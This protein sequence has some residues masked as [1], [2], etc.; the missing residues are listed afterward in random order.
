MPLLSRGVNE[1]LN[2]ECDYF[3]GI[4]GKHAK[5]FFSLDAYCKQY[6]E[7]SSTVTLCEGSEEFEDWHMN[8]SLNGEQVKLLCCPEDVEYC[9][10]AQAEEL[11]LDC[12]VPLCYSCKEHF[13]RRSAES[14]PHG[15]VKR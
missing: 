7:V 15:S 5:K 2:G 13:E 8:V 10:G 3:L 1:T 12:R 6:G 14:H 9:G 4:D 11:C